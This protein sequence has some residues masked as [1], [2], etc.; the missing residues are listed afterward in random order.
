VYVVALEGAVTECE[1]APASDQLAN[2]YCVPATGVCGEVVASVWFVPVVHVSVCVLVYV[3][4]STVNDSPGGL[5]P[6]V[7]G[8]VVWKFAVTLWGAFMVTV[9]EALLVFATKPVQLVKA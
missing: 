9:V 3:V 8:T 7:T 4:P 6:T 1:I 5:L 2:V